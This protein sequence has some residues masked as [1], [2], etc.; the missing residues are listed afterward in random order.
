MKEDLTPIEE[1]IEPIEAITRLENFVH[2]NSTGGISFIEPRVS[3]NEVL[4][5]LAEIKELLKANREKYKHTKEDV[6][7]GVRFG[8]YLEQTTYEEG[9]DEEIERWYNENY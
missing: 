1:L 8:V 4:K 5:A 6:I 3:T 2:I 7:K 9:F